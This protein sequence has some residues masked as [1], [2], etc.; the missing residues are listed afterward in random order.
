MLFRVIAAGSTP[1]RGALLAPG[2]ALIVLE[3]EN[4]DAAGLGISLRGR[5][6]RPPYGTV[7]V[8]S[9]RARP[10]SRR[11][12]CHPKNP[13]CRCSSM[14]AT[15]STSR[16]TNPSL[17]LIRSRS[18]PGWIRKLAAS[19]STSCSASAAR[20]SAWAVRPVREFL[21][22]ARAGLRRQWR[23]RT[24]RSP[25]PAGASPRRRNGG[26][27]RLDAGRDRSRPRRSQPPR[28]W[29]ARSVCK[30]CL[31]RRPA[32]SSL[33][34][35]RFRWSGPW[36]H[37]TL[38]RT[39]C[40]LRSTDASRAPRRAPPCRKALGSGGADA[41]V[42][43]LLR[44]MDLIFPAQPRK[45]DDPAQP[46]GGELEL[47]TPDGAGGIFVAGWLRDP[48]GMVADVSLAT[49]SDRVALTADRMIGSAAP[50]SPSG[51]RRRRTARLRPQA[52]S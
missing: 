43:Q 1:A 7:S 46:V 2:V 31:P 23:D 27:A 24:R 17:R 18:R 5:P 36:T 30:S 20:R 14:T 47:A 16:C 49:A 19:S 48:L 13:A 44:E 29:K 35:E 26:S 50:T 45:I 15:A 6:L 33:R 12:A 42:T 37:R 40:R 3:G 10:G 25:N 52:V 9:E 41:A 4:R 38:C 32:T 28:C 34:P 11:C 8:G 51:S 21:R 39:S 22:P